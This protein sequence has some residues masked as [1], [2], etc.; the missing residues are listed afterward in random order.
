MK[1]KITDTVEYSIINAGVKNV[2]NRQGLGKK[3]RQKDKEKNL[4]IS[5]RAAHLGGAREFCPAHP[6]ANDKTK[7][8]VE[9]V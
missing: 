6:L 4:G 8:D 5:L 3:I 1:L 7:M 9:I 2:G